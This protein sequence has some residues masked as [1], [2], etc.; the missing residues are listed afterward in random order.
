MKV[1]LVKKVVFVWF[2][3]CLALGKK[4]LELYS[5]EHGPFKETKLK[6]ICKCCNTTFLIDRLI[7]DLP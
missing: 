2:K 4:I 1:S 6:G 5:Y 3:E 7:K